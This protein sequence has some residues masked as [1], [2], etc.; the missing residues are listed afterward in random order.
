M[1]AFYESLLRTLIP[2]PPRPQEKL[3]DLVLRLGKLNALRRDIQKTQAHLRA[4]KAE[5]QGLHP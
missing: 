5:L 4:L 1:A 2:L 3:A